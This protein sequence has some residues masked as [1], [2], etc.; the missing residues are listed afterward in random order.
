MSKATKD[1]TP[2]AW[3]VK[4]KLGYEDIV[5]ERLIAE[6]LARRECWTVTP[7]VPATADRK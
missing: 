4:H 2:L 7:L 3:H 1:Q 6:S 5:K